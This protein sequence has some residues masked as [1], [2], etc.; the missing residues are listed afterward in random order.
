MNWDRGDY[1]MEAEKQLNNKAVYKNLNFDK[2]LMPNLTSKS[3]RL[4]ESLK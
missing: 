1:I 2:D 3:N 4:F